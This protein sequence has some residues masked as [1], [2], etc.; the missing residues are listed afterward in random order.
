[1][2][3]QQENK[4]LPNSSYQFCR[5]ES[6]VGTHICKDREICKRF[7]PNGYGVDYKDFW[8]AAECPKYESKER[9]SEEPSRT[10][11]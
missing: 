10:E 1:M 9:V 3:Q 2:K 8:I 6:P 7:L 4:P 5:G 11:W